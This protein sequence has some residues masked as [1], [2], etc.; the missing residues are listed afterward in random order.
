MLGALVQEDENGRRRVKIF[1]GRIREDRGVEVMYGGEKI[2]VTL[3]QRLNIPSAQYWERL[4]AHVDRV[5]RKYLEER[6]EGREERERCVSIL[7]YA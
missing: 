3:T 1:K 2:R 7:D 6:P 5:V 4:K